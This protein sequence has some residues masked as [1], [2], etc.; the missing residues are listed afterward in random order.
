[1]DHTRKLLNGARVPKSPLVGRESPQVLSTQ[2]CTVPSAVGRQP[3]LGHPYSSRFVQVI[4]R[5]LRVRMQSQGSWGSSEPAK[6]FTP[7]QSHLSL[8]GSGRSIT[9]PLLH[10]PIIIMHGGLFHCIRK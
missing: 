9:A 6:A 7:P 2:P 1:M 4:R 5:I 10:M 3:R 8:V